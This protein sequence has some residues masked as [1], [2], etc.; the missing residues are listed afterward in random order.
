MFK[1]V[2][3]VLIAAVC[4]MSMF[5]TGCEKNT[6]DA[7][8]DGIKKETLFKNGMLAVMLDDLWGYINESGEML[9]QP[10]YTSARNFQDN[11]LA[12]VTVKDSSEY[13]VINKSGD[14]VTDST[15]EVI[16]EFDKYGVARVMRTIKNDYGVENKRWGLINEKGEEILAPKYEEIGEFSECGWALVKDIGFYGFVNTKGNM[17]TAPGINGELSDLPYTGA[18]EFDKEGMARVSQYYDQWYINTNGEAVFS[19]KYFLLGDFGDADYTYALENPD[20]EWIYIDRKENRAFGASFDCARVFNKYGLAAANIGYETNYDMI[21]SRGKWG[22]INTK[23]EFVAQP[24]YDEIYDFINGAALYKK[25]GNAG[26]INTEGKSIYEMSNVDIDYGYLNFREDGY[27]VAP[28]M[29]GDERTYCVIDLDGNFIV[30]P[31]IYA[32]IGEFAKCGPAAVKT[33]DGAYGYI[34]RQGALVIDDTRI[35]WAGDFAD[36]GLARVRSS[37]NNKWG[38]INTKGEYI[39]KPQFNDALQFSNIGLA[40]VVTDEGLGYIDEKGRY[41]F[42]PQFD[43]PMQTIMLNEY[44]FFDDGYAMIAKDSKR[45]IVNS[46]GEIVVEPLYANIWRL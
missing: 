26:Y 10:Q 46:K 14:V 12:I 43:A 39:V 6:D 7:E 13:S 11:G 44:N 9:I 1:K 40:V 19:K 38:F 24:V 2:T 8:K 16:R 27:A 45:G 21:I 37:E 23:G 25:D 29:N 35:N 22:L 28:H 42:E 17:M 4:V 33:K 34:G 30:P 18:G 31:G 5:L 32:S 36:N 3:C 41:L 15:Y 20:D